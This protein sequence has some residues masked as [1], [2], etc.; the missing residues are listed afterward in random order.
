M[1]QIRAMRFGDLP[2]HLQAMDAAVSNL[3]PQERTDYDAFMTWAATVSAPT[4]AEQ[5]F[6]LYTEQ[7]RQGRAWIVGGATL[8]AVL[9][10]FCGWLIWGRK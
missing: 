10:G 5:G 3:G 7:R 2:Q 6:L 4:A 9:G 1:A 8:A